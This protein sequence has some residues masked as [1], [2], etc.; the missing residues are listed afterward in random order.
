MLSVAKRYALGDLTRPSPDYE[1][2]DLGRVARAMDEA[3]HSLGR[4]RRQPRARSRADGSDPR[5]HD[6]GRAGGQRR[7]PT[8]ARQRRR[9]PHSQARTR[10][11]PSFVHRSHP[12]PGHRRAHRPRPGRR[13]DRGP[14]AVGH[15]RKH[16]HAGGAGR[17]GGDQRAWR[18]AG[19]ARHHRAAQG[20]SSAPRFRRERVARIAHAAHRDQGLR[21][22]VAR[23][24]GRC[25]CAREVPRHHSPPCDADGA[26]GQGSVAAGTAGRRPGNPRGR[27]DRHRGPA[28]R[29]RQ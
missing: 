18:G 14:R 15:P 8:A 11:P 9:A 17:A 1:D 25:G 5:E 26:A 6:R 4:A 28:A 3:V 21:R 27:A 24:S 23:R 13:R 20:R 7:R 10:L 29:Y 19:D 2:D 12:S 16:P 22:S